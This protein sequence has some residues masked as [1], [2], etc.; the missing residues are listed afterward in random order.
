MDFHSGFSKVDSTIGAAHD[1]TAQS[2]W[3]GGDLQVKKDI[4]VS[5]KTGGILVNEIENWVFRHPV[6]KTIPKKISN[7][8]KVVKKLNP[9]H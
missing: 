1:C 6:Y 5:V 3:F 2:V 7:L 4:Q 9:L 8:Y